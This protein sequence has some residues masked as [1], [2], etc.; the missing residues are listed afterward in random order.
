MPDASGHPFRSA[1]GTFWA[2]VP[3]MLEIV[4]GAAF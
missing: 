3:W 2:H 1:L 4:S